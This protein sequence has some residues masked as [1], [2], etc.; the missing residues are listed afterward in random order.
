MTTYEVLRD[1][2]VCYRERHQ[3]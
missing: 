2:H 1:F 3:T